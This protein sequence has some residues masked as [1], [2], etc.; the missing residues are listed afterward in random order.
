MVY[1]CR[2]KYNNNNENVSQLGKLQPLSVH[3]SIQQCIYPLK[4]S[5]LFPRLLTFILQI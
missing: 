5:S 1:E 4:L 2:Y 3:P